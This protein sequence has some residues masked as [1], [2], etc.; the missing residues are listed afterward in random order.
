MNLGD[1]EGIGWVG[2]YGVDLLLIRAKI[3]VIDYRSQCKLPLE[4]FR[5]DALRSMI[6]LLQQK[7]RWRKGQESDK[8]NIILK[9]AVHR[10]TQF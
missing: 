6:S 1:A 5:M 7:L 9:P 4:K 8:E 2:A 3:Q 10:P